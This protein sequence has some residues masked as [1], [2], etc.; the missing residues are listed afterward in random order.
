MMRRNGLTMIELL[1]ILAVIAILLMLLLPAIQAAREAASRLQSQNNQRQLIIATHNFASTHEGRLPSIDGNS[2]SANPGVS[3]FGGIYYFSGGNQRLFVGPADPSVNIY[4]IGAAGSY[5]ANGQVFLGNPNLSSDIPDGTA[6]TIALAEHYSM[7]CQVHDFVWGMTGPGHQRRA[8]F[9]DRLCGDVVPI[10][11]PGP[12]P[13]TQPSDPGLTFQVAPS[14]PATTC[15]SLIPQTP[16]RAGLLTAMMDGSCRI[17][18]PG[19]S[20]NTFWA[21][22]TPAGGEILNDW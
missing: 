10:T 8:T 21:V 16:Y 3:F 4:N 22:V 1:A 9:A 17:I 13:I 6:S 12:P 11:T 15:F 14:P 2:T 7:H 19:V 5:A 20:P 18:S